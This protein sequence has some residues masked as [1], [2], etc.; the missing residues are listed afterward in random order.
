[1]IW[2]AITA[3]VL[4]TA[5]AWFLARALRRGHAG[6]VDEERRQLAVVRDRL[7][8]QLNELDV[9]GADRNLDAAITADERARIEADL[10]RVLRRLDEIQPKSATVAP[11]P[12]RA[13]LTVLVTLLVA[14]PLAGG[15]VYYLNH[16]STLS[17]LNG[18]IVAMEQGGEG[19]V[20][21]QVF[22]MVARLENRLKEDPNDVAGWARLG[23]AYA[24][25]G[26]PA[27]ARGAYERA[28]KLA[29]N[30]LEVLS[31]YAWTLYNQ[32]PSNTGEPVLSLYTRLIGL[33]PDHRDALWFLGFAAYQKGDYTQ[34]IKRWER[35][36]KLV[37]TDD[38]AAEHLR[39]VIAKAREHAAA[40]RSTRQ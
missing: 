4:T 28:L 33:D 26:R 10:A 20:P 34:A 22:E 19:Q 38:P 14:L 9:E 12:R 29:P 5:T 21:A 7:L 17:A 31:D 35:L 40:A 25:L 13:W 1:M 16:R 11:V 2:L 23:R 32:D 37:P 24:V 6:P 39:N 15:G 27:D 30:D 8:T 3:V 18:G 36:L